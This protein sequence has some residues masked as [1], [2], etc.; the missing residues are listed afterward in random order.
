MRV[1]LDFGPSLYENT[2]YSIV[3]DLKDQ[4][5]G[6]QTE[7][8]DFACNGILSAKSTGMFGAALSETAPGAKISEEAAAEKTEPPDKVLNFLDSLKIGKEGG[9]GG[10]TGNLGTFGLVPETWNTLVDLVKLGVKGGRSLAAAVDWAVDQ[11][12]ADHPDEAKNLDEDAARRHFLSRL[13]A[14]A[15]EEHGRIEARRDEISNRLNFIGAEAARLAKTGEGLP[16][17]L[18]SER[19]ALTKEDREAARKLYGISV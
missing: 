7:I 2:A 15:I 10:G 3:R 11:L 9:A 16:D 14:P 8:S 6:T 18:K 4:L 19:Y 12:R 17:D 1:I 5:R 13:R